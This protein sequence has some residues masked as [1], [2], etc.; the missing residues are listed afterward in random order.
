[1]VF[2][3]PYPMVANPTSASRLRPLRMRQSFEQ[4][5]YEVIDLS[6]TVTQRRERFK[7]L[8][9]RLS[10]GARPDFLY[11]ENSTQ[12]N[13]L[14]TSIRQGFAP[15]LDYEVFR[16]ARRY[17]IPSGVFYRDVYWKFD[18]SGKSNVRARFIKFLNRADLLGYR[19]NQLHF[20]LPSLPMASV[21]GLGG[22][23]SFSALPPGSDQR[24][25]LD[26]PD[27]P[28]RLF[29]V[30]GLGGHYIMD[31]F[32]S[33]LTAMPIALDLCTPQSNWAAV[34]EGIPELRNSN[35]RVH[36]LASGELGTLY[37]AVHVGVLAMKPDAYRDFAAPVKLFEYFSYGKPVIV[38]KG[39]NA[40]SIV[41]KTG[42][43]WAVD[44][45]RAE[46]LNLLRR[47]T[48]EQTEVRERAKLAAQAAVN[49]TWLARA[50]EVASVLSVEPESSS[51]DG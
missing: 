43:G 39:T 49:N 46:I 45:N 44:W 42:A 47:L 18:Q 36:H 31:E 1:M 51:I 19:K 23:D 37:R 34:Q 50:R 13:V 10:K 8:K 21:L 38:T 7:D 26:L 27:W 4:L 14:A 35:I 15:I 22:G 3:A 30:G 20:F 25:V 40:A 41:E 12:P 33:A 2:H 5:G 28:M 17:G 24:E 32:L 16:L 9:V 29:Y 6:G 48:K 11:S